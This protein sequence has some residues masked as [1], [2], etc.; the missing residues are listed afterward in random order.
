MTNEEH[1]ALASRSGHIES[2][3]SLISVT[4]P[5]ADDSQALRWAARSGNKEIV[6]ILI[7][8]SDPKANESGA[9]REAAR[10]GYKEIVEM[11]LPFSDPKEN[12]SEALRYAAGAGYEEIV[13]LLAPV[14]DIELAINGLRSSEDAQI[15][16]RG[17]VAKI[18]SF[19]SRV[20]L[21]ATTLRMSPTFRE[22]VDQ[23][24]SSSRE[25]MATQRAQARRL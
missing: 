13:E 5:K 15:L 14:S 9:L 16:I 7:P 11:L 22:C 12:D 23:A 2:V 25:K 3:R 8:V 4:D 10:W 17:T 24:R 21:D 1:L 20:E 6:E 18:E 19:R